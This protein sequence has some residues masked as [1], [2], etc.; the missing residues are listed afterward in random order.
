M[1]GINVAIVGATGLVGQT[2]LKVLEER[3][4]PIKELYCF[5]SSRSAGKT[6]E[7]KGKTYVVE[8]LTDNMILAT[9]NL[10]NVILL[11]ADEINTLDIISADNMIVTEKAVKLIEEVL[12]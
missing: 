12:V 6:I 8:E 9:R 2:F 3:N 1:N 5:A 4:F 10:K 7:F 11:Q